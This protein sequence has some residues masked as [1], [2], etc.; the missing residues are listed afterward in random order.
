MSTFTKSGTFPGAS[1]HQKVPDGLFDEV[2]KR[3]MV[4]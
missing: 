4:N 2:K 3:G 1:S